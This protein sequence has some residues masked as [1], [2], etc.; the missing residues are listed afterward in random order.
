MDKKGQIKS[1]IL[2][3]ISLIIIGGMLQIMGTTSPDVN[4][5]E[6]VNV[7]DLTLTTYWQGKN[8]SDGNWI[9]YNHLD[10]DKDGDIAFDDCK[11]VIN[12]ITNQSCIGCINNEDCG[13]CQICN[14][15]YEC[16]N[17]IADNGNNCND[18]CTYCS[19]GSCV[20]RNAYDWTECSQTCYSCTD[21]AGPA[22]NCTTDNYTEGFLCE[23]PGKYCDMEL[24]CEDLDN[25]NVCDPLNTSIK[26]PN[27]YDLFSVG[28]SILFNST[29]NGGYPPY[30]HSWESSIDGTLN[31]SQTFNRNNLSIGHHLITL[32]ITDFVGAIDTKNIEIEIVSCVTVVDNGNPENKLDIVFLGDDYSAAEIGNFTL[33]INTHYQKLLSYEPFTSNSNKIN[34][35]RVDST[36]DLECYYNCYG[37][38][39]LIC[40]N[41]SKAQ[42]LASVC[43]HD[44]III[45]VNNNTYGGS[46]GAIA[47]AYRGDGRVTTHEFGHS[48]GGL[49]DH[50]FVDPPCSTYKCM[51]C[52][53][54][55]PFATA[56]CNCRGEL[57]TKLS[58]YT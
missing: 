25:D 20:D 58:V 3:F 50:Y 29:V 52:S 22:D 8:S 16:E 31:N 14:A 15:G 54:N 39:R 37:T 33:D 11:I 12:C 51:M 53:L 27:A 49:P 7:V 5:D 44:E 6:E 57:E 26:F 30:A 43:P 42:K 46:G 56:P 2:I 34:I 47:V 55:Y 18:D 40:C 41:N 38:P 4:F 36:I 19:N 35:Y 24:C 28:E 45:I 10:L 17:I 21:I 32:T 23:D 13:T 1:I 9:D 48:F